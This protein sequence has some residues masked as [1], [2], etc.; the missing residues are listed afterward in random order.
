MNIALWICQ[1]VLA[2]MFFNAG[3]LKAFRYEK[4]KVQDSSFPALRAFCQG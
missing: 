4:A 3:I 1:G 2:A